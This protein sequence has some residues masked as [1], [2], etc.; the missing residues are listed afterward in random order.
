MKIDWDANSDASIIPYAPPQVVCFIII[1]SASSDVWERDRLRK[2][3]LIGARGKLWDYGFFTSSLVITPTAEQ[4]MYGDIV[5]L[6]L[7]ADEDV[8][9]QITHKN[10]LA[11]EWV[12]LRVE[13]R[14]ILKVECDTWVY[15]AALA[16]WL[17]DRA[18]SHG[19]YG[20]HL[21]PLSARSGTIA[22]HLSANGSASLFASGSYVLALPTAQLISEV[23]RRGEARLMPSMD[24][25]SVGLAAFAL[26]IQPVH[27]PGFKHV[28]PDDAAHADC[29]G[30]GTLLY[31]RPGRCCA[32]VDSQWHQG[33]AM[34]SNAA[35][36][37]SPLVVTLFIS[38]PHQQV[39]HSYDLE[40]TVQIAAPYVVYCG[41]AAC[42]LIA[43]ARADVDKWSTTTL[44]RGWTIQRL[45]YLVANA[46]GTPAHT[47]WQ[48]LQRSVT[49]PVDWG[50][51]RG[52]N[53]CPSP[54]FILLWLSKVPL[55]RQAM[56]E[57]PEQQKFAWVD[58]GFNFYRMVGRPVPPPPW[59]AFWP[60][61]GVA[62]R[63][64]RDACDA[65]YW[66]RTSRRPFARC[67][68][69]AFM[70]GSRSGW[71]RFI[72]AYLT[73][74]EKVVT[75]QA[76]WGELQAYGLCSDQDLY[77]AV[78]A[79]DPTLVEELLPA[80]DWSWENIVS[81]KASGQGLP[82]APSVLNSS[83][84]RLS[85]SVD[86][87]RREHGQVV[88][89]VAGPRSAT[90][91]FAII[92][93]RQA[94]VAQRDGLRRSWLRQRSTSGDFDYAFFVGSSSSVACSGERVGDLV[95]LLNI[96]DAYTDL[97]IKVLGALSWAASTVDAP[98]ILKADE[99][100]WADMAAIVRYLRTYGSPWF[101]GGDLGDNLGGPV[102]REGK[103]AV[104]REL[105]NFSAYPVYPYGGGYVL[106]KQTAL[107][108]VNMVKR[109]RAPLLRNVEDACVG[110]AAKL[111]SIEP[112]AIAG[113]YSS[114][115]PRPVGGPSTRSAW[116]CTSGTMLF[117]KPTDMQACD[118]CHTEPI[119]AV[120]LV[121]EL[122]SIS[123]TA[124]GLRQNLLD[125]SNADAFVVALTRST[126][127]EERV[128]EEE[129]LR[130]LGPR[131]KVTRLGSP[132]E[133]LDAYALK[134]T[135]S[136]A[137]QSRGFVGLG[138][139]GH[140]DW[141]RKHAEQWLTRQACA[142]LVHASEREQGRR[143]NAYARVRLDTRLFTPISNSV[144]KFI[145][146]KGSSSA[147]VAFVPEGNEFGEDP[148]VKDVEGA[149]VMHVTDKMLI[150]DQRAFD[151][152]A[153]VWR[154]MINSAVSRLYTQARSCSPR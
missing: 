5:H 37:S 150:G 128:K 116:C 72:H 100:T 96:S 122:R 102:H 18:S 121:G 115:T 130:T 9:S 28:G 11:L 123:L 10:R 25:A 66:S 67:V 1:P 61:R 112:T 3:W 142:N 46:L 118:A 51:R 117:H 85:G 104:P 134:Q 29:C 80:N 60:V 114:M 88:A 38:L 33:R 69:G 43:K 24:D 139:P 45:L 63:R 131:V 76:V 7:R 138:Q 94:H 137:A 56:R 99:N 53:A 55:L 86:Q 98:F 21:E 101:Y 147:P 64:H 84:A 20:G 129:V 26:G 133:L 47:L 83:D 32:A 106:S 111:L 153:S 91:C 58:A 73:H 125:A 132:E 90:T 30:T 4:V 113:F 92:L 77:E 42:E 81:L 65:Q 62:A 145:A 34:S 12:L 82:V 31:H 19:W 40:R 13:T 48:A 78:A 23:I 70:Y 146:A 27:V 119:H 105:Y 59:L 109:G 15:P 120:C 140:G 103:W 22:P 74:V 152:D 2:S 35:Q 126:S 148:F 16:S 54:E 71:G 124:P 135:I 93:S 41:G 143:Y 95:C 79:A 52:W 144:F 6:S 57:F 17:E 39:K 68:Y 127:A 107:A 89:I 97:A 50:A 110:I 14:Y 136:A 151:A 87:P 75:T 154:T 44:R 49:G 108:V 149:D 141:P 36:I 8:P